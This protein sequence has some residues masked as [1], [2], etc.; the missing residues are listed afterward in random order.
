MASRNYHFEES[1]TKPG[2]GVI[3]RACSS[4]H[5]T[6]VCGAANSE[7]IDEYEPSL[8][9]CATSKPAVGF[10]ISNGTLTAPGTNAKC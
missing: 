1:D 4:F 5:E 10:A 9:R 7:A 2:G 6:Y 8:S 3:H